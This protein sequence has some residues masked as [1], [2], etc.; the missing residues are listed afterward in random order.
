M[1]RSMSI[2]YVDGGRKG[3]LTNVKNNVE[4]MHEGEL[5]VWLRKKR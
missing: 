3:A 1:V 4:G 2:V 5:G